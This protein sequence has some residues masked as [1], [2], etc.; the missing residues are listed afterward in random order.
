MHVPTRKGDREVVYE[1]T[2]HTTDV[3]GAGTTSNCYITLRGEGGEFGPCA[4][5][6]SDAH[7]ARPGVGV[8]AQNA[9]DV[10]DIVA[11][12][13]EPLQ[14]IIISHD[15][16]GTAPSWHLGTVTL[17]RHRS[18]TSE[19]KTYRFEWNNWVGAPQG[20]AAASPASITIFPELINRESYGAQVGKTAH[21]GRPSVAP[22]GGKAQEGV[23]GSGAQVGVAI[24][25][26]ALSEACQ[27]MV[28][29]IRELHLPS[30][31]SQSSGLQRLARQL[32][33]GKS[34]A[35]LG[36]TASTKME[37]PSFC[38]NLS[39][40]L[41]GPRQVCSEVVEWYGACKMADTGLSTKSRFTYVQALASG[42]ATAS[43]GYALGEEAKGDL[44]H[45]SKL[46][47]VPGLLGSLAVAKVASSNMRMAQ[48]DILHPPVVEGK[49][50][51]SGPSSH[52]QDAMEE[53]RD[54]L[55][56]Q[57][58]SLFTIFKEIDKDGSGQIDVNE[59]TAA[60]QK[61]GL[62]MPGPRAERIF[63]LLDASGD[64]EIEYGEF[65]AAFKPTM[66]AYSYDLEAAS[67]A[68][69]AN[70]DLVIVFVDPKTIN[71]SL[72][73]LALI[74]RLNAS[75]PNKLRLACYVRENTRDDSKLRSHL[76]PT[77]RRRLEQ[78][79]GLSS[80]A[81]AG[82]LPN[83]WVPVAAGAAQEAGMVENEIDQVL[84]WIKDALLSLENLA[85]DQV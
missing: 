35:A 56:S 44:G 58:D 38:R 16:S 74:T 33:Q 61:L 40:M 25:K 70:A 31:V 81:L 64:G 43:P 12:N 47:E 34:A 60:L 77:A 39:V 41:L 26:T 8:L 22:A 55:Q 28:S 72:R 9:L 36:G 68:A 3:P 50:P 57:A 52:L 5:E 65:L 45:M 2:C 10:F 79:M 24:N 75:F 23:A 63:K 73:E 27:S 78:V 6:R 80:N 7:S 17:R 62:D 84:L 15:M 59:W 83:L 82:H 20:T 13:V 69:A 51:S 85:V 53:I 11:L 30:A 4:L 42:R 1:V 29:A 18:T 54:S 14:S 49:P 67:E 46:A 71:Y 48:V 37:M 66:T 21:Q 32:A 19:A 76:V